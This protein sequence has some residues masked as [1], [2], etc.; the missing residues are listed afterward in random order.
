MNAS[1]LQQLLA[2]YFAIIYSWQLISSEKPLVGK[3]FNHM[4]QRDFTDLFYTDFFSFFLEMPVH[5]VGYA[6]RMLYP[7]QPTVL[8]ARRHLNTM[9][10]TLSM[11]IW[12]FKFH[13][14]YFLTNATFLSFDG[15]SYDL[16]LFN[17]E[18]AYLPLKKTTLTFLWHFCDQVNSVIQHQS[19]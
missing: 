5:L 17:K 3:N 14:E 4:S 9:L 2:L 7:D 13:L 12:K 15:L 16:Y 19:Y 8:L 10:L 1:I 6:K 18:P 11:N